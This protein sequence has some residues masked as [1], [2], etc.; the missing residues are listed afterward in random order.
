MQEVLLHIYSL[1]YSLAKISTEGGHLPSSSDSL[2]SFSTAAA[3]VVFFLAL[4]PS[5]LLL[6][7]QKGIENICAPCPFLSYCC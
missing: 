6:P 3:V 5:L 2:T 7:L 4:Q 1:C